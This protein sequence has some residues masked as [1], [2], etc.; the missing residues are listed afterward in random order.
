MANSE[1][2]EDFYDGYSDEIADETGDGA[3]A[4]MGKPQSAEELSAPSEDRGVAIDVDL[5]HNFEW[6]VETEP[7]PESEPDQGNGQYRERPRTRAARWCN[8]HIFTWVCSYLFGIFGVDRFM[9]GQIMLGIIKFGTFGGL[10]LWYLV[11]LV[12]AIVKSYGGEYRNSEDL[13]FDEYG[14]YLDPRYM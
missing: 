6:E 9:R 5:D 12:I 1:D 2:F 7:A 4:V 11:D 3:A 8:K 14:R 10:G 13:L